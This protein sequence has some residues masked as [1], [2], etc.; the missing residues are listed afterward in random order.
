MFITSFCA[1]EKTEIYSFFVSIGMVGTSIDSIGITW[2][3][4]DNIF[5]CLW[6]KNC[7]LIGENEKF[8]GKFNFQLI[9]IFCFLKMFTPPFSKSITM[10]DGNFIYKE[11]HKKVFLLWIITPTYWKL[12][13]CKKHKFFYVF[14]RQFS[15]GVILALEFI[16]LPQVWIGVIIVY[17]QFFSIKKIERVY[18]LECSFNSLVLK[19]FIIIEVQSRYKRAYNY[20]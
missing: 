1:I 18:L 8:I 19:I 12:F 2:Q 13:T 10:K 11:L 20:W 5:F 4:L 3:W 6:G 17:L 9:Y 7:W 14:Y 16:H 15:P